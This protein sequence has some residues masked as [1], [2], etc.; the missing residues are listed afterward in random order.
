MDMLWLCCENEEM[1]PK[2]RPKTENEDP[3]GYGFHSICLSKK[4]RKED[5]WF[6]SFKF[7]VILVSPETSSSVVT[8]PDIHKACN[9]KHLSFLPI[10]Q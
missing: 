2:K 1:T 10:S 7:Y 6:I 4:T 5:S 8:F 9:Q 3:V